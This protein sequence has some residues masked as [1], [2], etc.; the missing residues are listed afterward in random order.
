MYT[1]DQKISSAGPI[2][3]KFMT[4]KELVI[5][6]ID[7]HKISGEEAVC[8]LEAILKEKGTI[9]TSPWTIKPYIGEPHSPWD[10]ITYKDTYT[11]SNNIK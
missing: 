1:K 10:T 9:T 7:E 3:N 4:A 2:N 11:V 8:L 5:K 6:L